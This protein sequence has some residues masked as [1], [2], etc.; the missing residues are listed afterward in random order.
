MRISVYAKGFANM[1]PRPSRPLFALALFRASLTTLAS[2]K[3][4]RRARPS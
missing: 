4:T 3:H 1:T 2:I